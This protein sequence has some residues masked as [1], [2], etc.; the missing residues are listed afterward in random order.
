M[1]SIIVLTQSAMPTAKRIQDTIGG[2]IHA[3]APRVPDAD[4]TFDTPITFI[5]TQF[6]KGHTIIGICATAILV[7]AIAPYLHTKKSDP[8]IISISEDGKTIVPIIGGHYGGYDMAYT[9]A[10][11]FHTTPAITNASNTQ[12]GFSL[13]DLPDGWY[14]SNPD[15]IK[16]ITTEL[17]AHTPVQLINDTNIDFPYADYFCESPTPY[18]VRITP[19]TGYESPYTLVI[20]VPCIVIGIGCERHIPDKNLHEFLDDMLQKH[21]VSVHAIKHFA[22]VDI[23]CDESAIKSLRDTYTPPLWLF[24]V[25]TLGQYTP[26]NP[27]QMV[28]DEIGC[29]GVC[30]TAV[31]ASNAKLIVEKKSRDGCTLALGITDDTHTMPRTG[32]PNGTLH[33]VGI[34]AGD[35]DWRTPDATHAL[36]TSDV[37]IGYQLYL[38]LIA[39]II[40]DTPTIRSEMGEEITRCRMALDL[41]ST[42]KTVALV[43]SGDASI[44]ALATLIFELLDTHPTHRAWHGIQLHIAPGISA[45]QACSARVG[46][47]FNHDFC[48]LSLSDLL[49]PRD[50]ILK[51]LHTASEGDFVIAFYN[52][53]SQR[54]RTLLVQ[55]RDILLQS[56]P[57]T[58]PVVIGRN[59]GR[60]NESI[61]H[62]TLADFDTDGVD[63]LSLVIVGNSETKSFTSAG[64]TY[65]YTPRGYTKK[66]N[67][68]QNT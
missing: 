32:R 57:A 31:L 5:G 53:Q 66:I 19:H 23:K 33:I 55:A 34:G 25:A 47:P 12:L 54:R 30:E 67:K 46:A 40:H 43:C 10:N 1:I 2:T 27:S 42:G 7:R 51:R 62:T 8:S 56:R 28:Y 11:I 16:P 50:I 65:T 24:D 20:Y 41:A 37:V 21:T 48:L 44:Y 17:L 15:L 63:M 14:V 9:L 49:T 36:R 58:T 3:Y 4:Y 26:P 39:D 18:Q 68:G 38:D 64:K 59:I 29:Y 45:F 60:E 52:P 22:S 61:I 35:A 13:D 6:I